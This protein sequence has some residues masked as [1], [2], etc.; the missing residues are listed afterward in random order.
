MILESIGIQDFRKL[1]DRLVIDE[2]TPGLN[3]ICGP[4]EAGK[5][6]IAEA[7]RIAFLERYKVSGLG[8]LVPKSRPDGQPTV[9]VSFDIR[10]VKHTLKKQ[11]VRKQRCELRI[12]TQVF[13][14]DEAEEELAK[15]VG[16]SRAERGASRPEHA[17]IP[18][19]LWVRQGQTNDVRDPGGHASGYIREALSKLAGGETSRGDDALINKVQGELFKLLTEK[20]KKPT[21]SLAAVEA[22]L[23]RLQNERDTLEQQLRNF[24]EDINRL[25]TL[26]AEFGEVQRSRPWEALQEKAAAALKR[27]E[28]FDQ[29]ERKH[30][31]LAQKLEI[32][33]MEHKALLQQEQLAVELETSAKNDSEALEA[34]LAAA[35]QAGE[36]YQRAADC[37]ATAQKAN[38]E[39]NALLETANAAVLANELKRQLEAQ[40][41]DISRIEE[42]LGKATEA[43][44]VVRELTRQA[45]LTEI[46]AEKMK[47]LQAVCD[48][49]V[50]LQARRDAA[51][52]RIEYRLTGTITVDG[53][54][55]EGEGVVLL[56][57]QKT[58]GL[59]GLG[60]L[61]I[62][63]GVSDVSELIA[64][65]QDLE[66][67][68]GKLLLELGVSSLVD[69]VERHTRWKSLTAEKTSH[70]K[71]L[72][73]HAPK[74]LDA[75]R[76]ELE[77]ARGRL[78]ATQ[79]RLQG[80]PDVSSALPVAD[81]KAS[82]DTARI[83]LEAARTTLMSASEAKT[84]TAAG[85]SGIR[86]RLEGSEA[87][88]KDP[89]F[90][91]RRQRC[92]TDLVDKASHISEY[93]RNLEMSTQQ[94]DIAKLDDPR[95]EA[96][97]YTQS[98]TLMRA[99]QLA[100]QQKI[101]SLRVQLETL[102]GTGLGDRLAQTVATIDQ[103]ESRRG[104]L[105]RRADALNLLESVLVEE[106]DAAV[107]ALRKPLTGRIEHYLK[108]IFPTGEM[109]VDDGL[110]P[111]GLL[112]GSQFETLDSLSYGTQEQLGFLARLAYADLLQSAGK[113]TLL[114]FDDAVVH[115]DDARR[116]AIKRALLDAASR[117]QILVFTCHPSAWNDLGVKQRHLEDLK[118][119][120]RAAA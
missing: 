22:D 112:R 19:L 88:L 107:A 69:A 49:M 38:D 100:R 53:A 74:G 48:Q 52:T 97:R 50:P 114:L 24:D 15:L 55:V 46:D 91:A 16:F 3:L 4:N 108:R 43:S 56:D 58:I 64:A 109:T 98:A 11:F 66:T 18:G 96:E 82:F 83:Q 44:E 89:E 10:G 106:R 84:Q 86:E 7:I 28:S 70:A 115:T 1:A 30:K 51:L 40:R 104:E 65:L 101:S 81:A 119:A 117:H 54:P 42:A 90:V 27:A 35:G 113:P 68:R 67:E 59:P 12:G 102:G 25:G 118:A 85:A 2:L 93:K 29:M 17:G 31:E 37:V 6:T 103:A 33:V 76:T 80:L 99:E 110:T 73:A 120:S 72:D 105:R 32:A 87:R 111:V 36:A 47:T 5:S 92:Q 13:T 63:P 26:Q 79:E 57:G 21:G 20:A 39:A 8:G 95:T 71:I 34:A 77:Q 75:L 41:S 94:L 60:E 61:V 45:A 14:E 9:E 116:D 62:I 23:S 78:A